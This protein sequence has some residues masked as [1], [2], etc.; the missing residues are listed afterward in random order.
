MKRTRVENKCPQFKIV[1]VENELAM[2]GIFDT[3]PRAERHIREVLPVYVEQGLFMDK[4]LTVKDFKIK[5]Y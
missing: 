4:S 2:H 1:E 3:L 5:E